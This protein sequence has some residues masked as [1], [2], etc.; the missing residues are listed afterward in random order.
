MPN[1]LVIARRAAP[2]TSAQVV[3]SLTDRLYTRMGLSGGVESATPVWP[4]DTPEGDIRRLVILAAQN[5]V[6]ME[7][8]AQSVVYNNGRDR[9]FNSQADVL[10]VAAAYL[11]VIDELIKY[12]AVRNG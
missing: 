2:L 8:V 4:A 12:S 10:A 1:N 11:T 7:Y 5:N 6:T 9:R 3:L